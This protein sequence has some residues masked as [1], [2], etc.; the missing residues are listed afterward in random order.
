MDYVVLCFHAP[1]PGKVLKHLEPHIGPEKAAKLYG[2]LIDDA[3]E[4]TQETGVRRIVGC[5]PGVSHP[6]FQELTKRVYIEMT[7]LGEGCA[8]LPAPWIQ[9]A[10]EAAQKKGGKKVL[11]WDGLTPNLTPK[12]FKEIFTRLE[13]ADYVLGPAMNYSNYVF[14]SNGKTPTGLEKVNWDSPREFSS[15][16]DCLDKTRATI[17]Q[18]V[19]YPRLKR[20]KDI[21]FFVTH[22]KEI[23]KLHAKQARHT[24]KILQELGLF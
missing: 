15:L 11:Y 1:E 16:I 10:L 4:M 19:I 23:H 14:A 20:A 13:K 2:A 5:S 12:L 21:P 24:V 8:E 17:H 18:H 22:L 7:D 6:F 3:L 9:K